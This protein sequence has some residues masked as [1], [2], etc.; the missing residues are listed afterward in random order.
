VPTSNASFELANAQ[1]MTSRVHNPII[2]KKDSIFNNIEN[3][4]QSQTT[5]EKSKP[6]QAGVQD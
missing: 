4:I 5:L 2:N 3:P 6:N 1:A